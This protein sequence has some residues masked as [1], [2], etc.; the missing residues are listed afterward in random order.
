MTSTSTF[1]L[2]GIDGIFGRWADPI[3]MRVV[4]ACPDELVTQWPVGPHLSQPAGIVNGGV[5][6]TVT[7]TL[8]G[9]AAALWLLARD[10]PEGVQPGD[11]RPDNLPPVVGL[12]NFTEFFATAGDGTLTSTCTPVHR[13]RTTQVWQ[14]S[15]RDE[16][17]RLI[18]RGQLRL[19]NMG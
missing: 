1:D 16:R 18:A 14:V 3:G 13:G 8:G 9:L 15:T 2:A 17:D 11:I 12:S 7:E 5:H 10:A 6:A 19:L 4:R